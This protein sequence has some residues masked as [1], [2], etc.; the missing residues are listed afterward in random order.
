M[1]PPW[2]GVVLAVPLLGKLLLTLF[3]IFARKRLAAAQN[4]ARSRSAKRRR[5]RR[6]EGRARGGEGGGEGEVRVVEVGKRDR[7]RAG[8]VLNQTGRREAATNRMSLIEVTF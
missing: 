7:R 4:R 6:E 1:L 8:N 5:A 3:Q 2:Q